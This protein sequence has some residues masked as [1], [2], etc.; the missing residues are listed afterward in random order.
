M[1]KEV[2]KIVRK[3]DGLFLDVDKD[4]NVFELYGFLNIYVKQ[5]EKSLNERE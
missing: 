1:E 3:D 2:F 4:V 5:L